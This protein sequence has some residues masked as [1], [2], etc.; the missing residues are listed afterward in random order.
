MKVV[1][2]LGAVAALGGA[3]EAPLTAAPS[4][5]HL[6]RAE[7]TLEP[8]FKDKVE[9]KDWKELQ[10]LK[11]G[12]L[13]LLQQPLPPWVRTIYSTV[14]E[15]VTPTIVGGVTFSAKPPLTTNG[16][17]PWVLLKKDGLPKVINPKLKNGQI[18]NG[19]PDYST[20]FKTATTVKYSKEELKA[21]NMKEGEVHEQV[22]YI[23]EDQTYLLLNPV[24]RCI[25]PFY[26]NK[27][28]AKAHLPEPFCFPQDNQQWIVGRTYF[29]TWYSGFFEKEVKQVKLLLTYVTEAPKQKGFKRGIEEGSAKIKSVFSSLF[30]RSE[31]LEKGGKVQTTHFFESD[32]IP[33]R[34]GMLAVEVDKLWLPE[35]VVF[36][37]KALISLLP[38]N[39]PEEEFDRIKNGI[40]VTLA[41]GTVVGKGSNLDLKKTE[42]RQRLRALGY[43]I[44]EGLD[45]EKWFIIM[46][47]PTCVLLA[48]LGMYAFVW[49]NRGQTD[50]SFLKK[51]KLKRGKRGYTDLPQWNGKRD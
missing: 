46:L 39:V 38:D 10:E 9:N 21:H 17:E 7:P 15:I 27:G 36:N 2:L 44:D 42:E 1:F 26:K 16:L 29:V 47:I 4:T 43:E 31:A 32:W 51:V 49:I 13:Q 41:R 18:K 45:F 24:M 6:S 8:R 40:V 50:L 25:P 20:W 11:A 12:K 34:S 37:R 22:E 48:A 33:V 5:V 35:L 30:S 28:M 19:V 23:D 14:V 3:L